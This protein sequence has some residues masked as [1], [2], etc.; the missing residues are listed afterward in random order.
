MSASQPNA[1][2][3]ASTDLETLQQQ[4]VS[5]TAWRLLP[6][7]TLAFI[8]NY[9]DRTSVGFAALSM[10]SDLGLT[11][12]QFGWGAGILFAGYCLL[13]VPSNLMLYRFGARRW[14]ARIMITWGLAA[15]A[16]ALAVGPK[17][18]YFAR[19]VLGVAEA[20]FFPGVT[21]YLATWFPAKFRTR[22]LAWFMVGVPVSSILSGPLSGLLLNLDGVLG[23]AGWK[24]MFILQGLPAS[25]IGIVVLLMLRD[26]PSQASWLSEAERQALIGM[27]AS[28]RREKEKKHLG[29]ALKDPRVLILT[30]IQFGFV[31]GSYGIGIW[32][33]TILKSHG[34]TISAI[35]LVSSVPYIFATVAMLTWARMV[36]RNGKKIANLLLTCLLGAGGMIVAALFSAF[37][38]ALIGITIAVI[39]VTTAR[40]VFWSIPTRFLSGAAAAGGLAF[41]NSVGTFGGFAGPFLV[42]WLKDQTGSFAM[43]MLGM[44]AM[45]LVST[46]LTAVLRS[47]VKDE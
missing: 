32:L 31:L 25:I 30:G 33:P 47:M 26:N 7:L 14:L 42:G 40:A 34:L 37:W 35:S 2:P 27:L 21:F 10:N 11:A 46:V 38:P 22:M 6:L 16:T 17:S 44:A 8:F 12:T 24:W 3:A 29:A 45:L 4:A 13:E 20:G 36:D 28:E 19:F 1:I 5:K 15:A 41:I 39:G 9:I 43:G 23:L 18:F